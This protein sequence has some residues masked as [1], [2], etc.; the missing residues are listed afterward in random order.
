MVAELSH[1]WRSNNTGCSLAKISMVAE[2][3]AQ[4]IKEWKRCSLAKISM[5]AE[6]FFVKLKRGG[7]CSLAKI[8]MVAEPPL[9]V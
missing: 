7:C 4:C 5:V 2:R 6:L 9:N 1:L 8:S 3:K